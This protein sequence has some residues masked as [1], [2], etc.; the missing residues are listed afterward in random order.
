[1][2]INHQPAYA[3]FRQS[4]YPFDCNCALISG[5]SSPADAQIRVNFKFIVNNLHIINKLFCQ[6]IC[7]HSMK[8][9]QFVNSVLLAT[10][11][12]FRKSLISS[13]SKRLSGLSCPN[14]AKFQ[15]IYIPSKTSVA[16]AVSPHFTEG[17]QAK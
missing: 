2:Y 10:I 4:G 12:C 9:I 13:S 17:T 14:T 1:M 7:P 8:P 15:Y 16:K 3:Q 11:T 6:L 5:C